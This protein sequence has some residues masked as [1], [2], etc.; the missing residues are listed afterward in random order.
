MKISYTKTI[1]VT[2][3][4]AIL[5]ANKFLA[6][7][8]VDCRFEIIKPHLNQNTIYVMVNGAWF[9]ERGCV[10]YFPSVTDDKTEFEKSLQDI[11]IESYY[12]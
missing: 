9:A 4:Q 2:T 5:E 3:R 12:E 11:L 8:N 1:E 6:S 7:K 10:M